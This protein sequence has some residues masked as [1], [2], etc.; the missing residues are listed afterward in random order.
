MCGA[1]LVLSQ[2]SLLLGAPRIILVGL[3]RIIGH[4]EERQGLDCLG[5]SRV[6]LA[7]FGITARVKKERTLPAALER[8]Q[9]MATKLHGHF[10]A[11]GHDHQT[12]VRAVHQS[13]DGSVTRVTASEGIP[14]S[15][16]GQLRVFEIVRS[17]VPGVT[18]D[19]GEPAVMQICGD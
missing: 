9:V 1:S 8:R 10:I 2:I 11:C 15:F 19:G 6:R 16:R 14:G 3:V 7:I 5:V 4:L 13:F 18:H 12:I 17:H